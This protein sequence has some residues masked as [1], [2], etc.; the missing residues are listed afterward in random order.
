MN[1]PTNGWLRCTA[2]VAKRELSSYFATPIAYV[3]LVVF[4]LLAGF[5]TFN[6][7]GFFEREQA[8]LYSFFT[9]HPWLYLFL[10]PA[11]SM[12]LWAEERRNGTIELLMTLPLTEGQTVVGKFVAAWI[13]AGIALALT[14]PIWLSVEYLGDPDRGA[15]V[16]GYVGSWLMGGAFLAIGSLVS[17]CSKNQVVA[18]VLTAAICFVFVLVDQPWF[19]DAISWMPA[20]FVDLVRSFGFMTRFDGLQ[21]GVVQFDAALYFGSL[22]ALLLYVNTLVVTHVK[23]S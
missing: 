14:F 4:L 9:F 16:S 23:A 7:G 15:I 13:F 10:V 3:F 22:V 1:A 18:F 8:N 19:V 12:R 11:I 17:A 6:L 21:K 5:L 2:I 20:I